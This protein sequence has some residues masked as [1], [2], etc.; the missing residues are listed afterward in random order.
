MEKLR[1]IL[2]IMR[3][4]PRYG[5]LSVVWIIVALSLAS[6]HTHWTEV[7]QAIRFLLSVGVPK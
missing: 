5:V 1:I 6:I 7:A 2:D 3:Q 4:Y